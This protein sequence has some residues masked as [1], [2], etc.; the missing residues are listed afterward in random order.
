MSNDRV[1]DV[2]GAGGGASAAATTYDSS[3]SVKMRHGNNT[4]ALRPKAVNVASGSDTLVAH[5]AITKVPKVDDIK[6]SSNE[7]AMK[8]VSR[9]QELRA[10]RSDADPLLGLR[11]SMSYFEAAARWFEGNGVPEKAFDAYELASGA[12]IRLMIVDGKLDVNACNDEIRLLNKEKELLE[13][14]ETKGVTDVRIPAVNE[15][16]PAVNARIALV[17]GM[18]NSNVE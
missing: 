2:S 6:I 18:K 5:S 14:Q 12:G 16:I 11:A 3:I 13:Q 4:A 7:D 15:R 9:A 10:T 1:G 17:E 8:A